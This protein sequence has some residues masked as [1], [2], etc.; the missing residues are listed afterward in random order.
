MSEG[1]VVAMLV[2][3]KAL[4]Q[5]RGT[6]FEH[7]LEHAFAK[8]SA[9]LKDLV[10]LDPSTVLSSI[11]FKSLGAS[12]ADL[13]IFNVISNAQRSQFEIAFTYMKPQAKVPERRLVHPYHLTCVQNLWYL[14]AFDP[15]RDSY[16][17][18]ALPR[19]SNPVANKNRFTRR[20]DFTPENVLGNAFGIL[21][22]RGSHDIKIE[23]DSF[24]AQYVRER[25]W[26]RSQKLEQRPR[27]VIRL[28]LTVPHL[29]EVLA[30]VLSW[31]AHAKVIGPRE[32]RHQVLEAGLAIA[33]TYAR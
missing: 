2:A 1:E 12:A 4:E 13:E 3:Q 33:K 20:E 16:R 23:F 25:T 27:G 24:A 28:E 19:I 10:T 22:G 14:L 6:P 15:S 5:Y 8:I 18:F 9:A 11:S 32:L 29:G 17:T 31:G 7:T 26:H 30:W 21:A